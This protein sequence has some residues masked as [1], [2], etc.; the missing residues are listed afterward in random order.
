[1]SESADTYKSYIQV[2]AYRCRSTL[3]NVLMLTSNVRCHRFHRVRVRFTFD[4]TKQSTV[5]IVLEN[6]SHRLLDRQSISIAD[7]TVLLSCISVRIPASFHLVVAYG[8]TC[9]NRLWCAPYRST[10]NTCSAVDPGIG[11]LFF[12]LSVSP[13]NHTYD[14]Y[15]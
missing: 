5:D 4:A 14:R 2:V 9:R 11:K 6:Q 7:Y 8:D 3:N 13:K 10:H 1:V 15:A 12:F